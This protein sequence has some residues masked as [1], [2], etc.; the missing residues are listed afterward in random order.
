MNCSLI[1]ELTQA[2]YEYFLKHRD[3]LIKAFGV[4]GVTEERLCAAVG[5]K[6]RADIGMDQIVSLRG[7]YNALKD[8]VNGIAQVLALSESAGAAIT[9]DNEWF[10][11]GG[12]STRS[13]IKVAS[14]CLRAAAL[15]LIK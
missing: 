14:L 11:H 10:R 12:Q 7:F 2:L 1:I 13:V 6:G 8:G 5:I 15:L 9:G 3:E 4:M